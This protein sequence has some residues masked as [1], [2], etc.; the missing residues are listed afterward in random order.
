VVLGQ[1]GYLVRL[2]RGTHTV[3]R[4]PDGEGNVLK[5]RAP[6]LDAARILPSEHG[7]GWSLEIKR[8]RLNRRWEGPEA[9]RMAGRILPAI[10]DGLLLPEGAGV[11]IEKHR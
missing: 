5:L 2:V 4:I 11:F 9:V 10:A 8:G 1:S 7:D 3:V 6:H